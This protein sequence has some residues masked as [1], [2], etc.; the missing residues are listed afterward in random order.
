MPHYI[1]EFRLSI[2]K[3]QASS[4]LPTSGLRF[5]Y[6][7]WF[8]CSCSP[9][10]GHNLAL[11]FSFRKCCINNRYCLHLRA[12]GVLGGGGACPQQP[13]SEA[14][15]RP[16]LRCISGAFITY[17]P[18]TPGLPHQNQTPMRIIKPV[19]SSLK[20]NADKLY[21]VNYIFTVLPIISVL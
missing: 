2:L 6:L 7:P 20:E 16:G 3:K 4:F 10:Q 8:A 11:C 1:F 21:F 12:L 17:T 9:H 5:L 19:M 18:R 15:P 13:A 14:G